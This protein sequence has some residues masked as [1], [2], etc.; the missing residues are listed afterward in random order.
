MGFK[1]VLLSLRAF[2]SKSWLLNLTKIPFL[3]ADYKMHTFGL[4]EPPLGID[5][6][7]AQTTT[8][9]HYIGYKL[10]MQTYR[11]LTCSSRVGSHP[12]YGLV[13]G[14]NVLAYN[15]RRWMGVPDSRK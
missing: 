2:G 6:T 9:C 8:L 1:I 12:R 13:L 3:Q 11:C 7:I 5:E 10:Q 14:V 4:L 15:E